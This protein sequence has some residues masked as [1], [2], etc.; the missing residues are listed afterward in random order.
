MHDI[1]KKTVVKYTR[2]G[3]QGR[4]TTN[5]VVMEK[6]ELLTINF[7]LLGLG[8]DIE[9]IVPSSKPGSKTPDF[10]MCGVSWEMKSPRG[11]GKYTM[12]DTIARA[13]RQ[14]ENVVID[15]RRMKVSSEK[16]LNELEKIFNGDKR[17]RR[18]LVIV[19]NQ[20]MVDYS[21]R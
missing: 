13:L 17:I 18:L 8:E 16:C 5:G 9:L 14:S 6:H 3:K 15:L 1:M 20:K 12:R 19:N 4:L 21:R 10:R 2:G 11:K 7:L